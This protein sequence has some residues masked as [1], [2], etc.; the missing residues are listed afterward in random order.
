MSIDF[1]ATK[2]VRQIN[3]RSQNQDSSALNVKNSWEWD[4]A[5][6]KYKAGLK[7]KSE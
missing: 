5:E 7:Q 6:K 1:N 2:F 3:K 4:Q